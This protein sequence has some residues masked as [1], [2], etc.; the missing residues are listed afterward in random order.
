VEIGDLLLSSN[1][2]KIFEYDLKSLSINDKQIEADN[3]LNYESKNQIEITMK[4]N[5]ALLFQIKWTVGLA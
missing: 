5:M 4:S 2:V 3:V 1:W